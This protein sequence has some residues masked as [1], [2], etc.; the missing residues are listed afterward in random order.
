MEKFGDI[1][2]RY[3]H[4]FTPGVPKSVNNV[5]KPPH[6]SS[7]SKTDGVPDMKSEPSHEMPI[8][9][10]DMGSIVPYH[11]SDPILAPKMEKWTSLTKPRLNDQ[12]NLQM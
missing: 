10:A 1:K 8:P 4:M 9:N 5:E 3:G 12:M 11:M 6:S 7:A 2:K